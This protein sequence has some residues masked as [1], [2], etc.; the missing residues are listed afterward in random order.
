MSQLY[1]A[2]VA[3]K[4]PTD[5]GRP[6]GSLAC[7]VAFD[8]DEAITNA[9]QA[10]RRWELGTHTH[11]HHFAKV[12]SPMG[13]YRILVGELNEEAKRNEYTVIERPEERF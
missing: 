3:N 11:D 7:F 5:T 13:P 1:V 2:V 4:Y 12:G 9:L 6:D 10:I 8:K